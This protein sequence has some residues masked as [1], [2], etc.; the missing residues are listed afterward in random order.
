VSLARSAHEHPHPD[1]LV[2]GGGRG[3][4]RTLQRG[5]TSKLVLWK[6]ERDADGN[7]D[8]HSARSWVRGAHAQSWRRVHRRYD[9]AKQE[10]ADRE[11]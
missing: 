4:G 1:L 5:L 7:A 2:R 10:G 11:V 9:D 8:V 3:T 6:A